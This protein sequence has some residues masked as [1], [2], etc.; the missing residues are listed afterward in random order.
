MHTCFNSFDVVKNDADSAVKHLDS[1][2]L[3]Q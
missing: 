2:V 1:V 3:G